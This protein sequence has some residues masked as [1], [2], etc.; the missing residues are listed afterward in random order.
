MLHEPGVFMTFS[1]WQPTLKLDGSP[2]L[3]SAQIQA[4]RWSFETHKAFGPHCNL[5]QA[6]THFRTPLPTWKHISEDLQSASFLHCP[7]L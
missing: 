4:E 2:L 3:P 1:G 5:L 6:S 7:I